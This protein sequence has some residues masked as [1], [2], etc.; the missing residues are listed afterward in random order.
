[1]STSL[2]VVTMNRGTEITTS[3][4]ENDIDVR[5]LTHFHCLLSSVLLTIDLLVI[6]TTVLTLPRSL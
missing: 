6:V 5:S 4:A 1:M 3:T 2:V